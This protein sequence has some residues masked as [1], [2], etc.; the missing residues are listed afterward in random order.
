MK[1]LICIIKRPK[2]FKNVIKVYDISG[3]YVYAIHA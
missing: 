1:F 2:T 3:K